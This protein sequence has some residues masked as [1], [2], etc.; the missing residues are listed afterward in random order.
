MNNSHAFQ[1]IGS[2]IHV[3][4]LTPKYAAQMIQRFM[5]TML[6][7]LQFVFCYLDDMIASPDNESGPQH[8]RT[9]L[10]ILNEYDLCINAAKCETSQGEISCTLLKFLVG[11]MQIQ[12]KL[13]AINYYI[14]AV[15]PVRRVESGADYWTDKQIMGRCPGTI[16]AVHFES[17]LGQVRVLGSVR[18]LQ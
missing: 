9:I 14:I 4:K 15:D 13:C 11:D 3:V 18:K 6:Q 16:W 10:E 7:G 8:V 17:R 2:S 12:P 1:L 5:N